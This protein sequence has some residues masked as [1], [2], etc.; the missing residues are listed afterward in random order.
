[1]DINWENFIHKH[2]SSELAADF[3][4]GEL[5]Q[6]MIERENQSWKLFIQ[7]DQALKA[8][9]YQSFSQELRSHFSFLKSVEVYPELQNPGDTLA[10]IFQSR[11]QDIFHWL[12]EKNSQAHDLLNGVHWHFGEHHRITLTGCTEETYDAIL[13]QDICSFILA[14]E[15]GREDT[16]QP[17]VNLKRSGIPQARP[18]GFAVSPPVQGPA[19]DLDRG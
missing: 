13:Q 14:P 15:V 16:Q 5:K 10:G 2:L 1:M 17:V 18:F 3:T 9:V 6:L 11:Q 12:E 7:L 8:P 4:G 19:N